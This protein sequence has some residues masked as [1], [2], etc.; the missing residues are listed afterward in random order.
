MTTSELDRGCVGDFRGDYAAIAE[1]MQRSWGE[2]HET[3]LLYTPEFLESAFSYPGASPR[4][5]R[6]CYHDDVPVAFTAGFQRNVVLGGTKLGLILHSFVTAD[7]RLK[8]QGYGRAAW[9]E[10]TRHT[11]AEGYDGTVN[12]CVEGDVMNTVIL[13]WAEA[14]SFGTKRIFSIPYLAAIVRPQLAAEDDADSP[15]SEAFLEAAR[16]IPTTVPLARIWT[17]E[18]AE[19]QCR[20]RLGALAVQHRAAERTGVLTAYA[21]DTADAARTRCA[22]VD[23]VLWGTLQADE[24]TVLVRKLM[25]RAAAAGVKLMVL[26]ALGYAPLDPFAA[27]GFRRI[28]RRLHTYLTLWNQAV[29]EAVSSLYLDVF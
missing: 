4:L 3:P 15:H 2:N 13:K 8:G 1:L 7:S 28:R 14:N 26:P 6:A 24:R 29:P 10:A 18:E 11:R 9:V 21:M 25:A 20:R 17:S 5:A 23:D 19:W 27:S 12:F 16:P 22:I